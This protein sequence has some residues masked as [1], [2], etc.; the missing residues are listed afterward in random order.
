MIVFG[1]TLSEIILAGTDTAGGKF[2]TTVYLT[3]GGIYAFLQ[4]DLLRNF[5]NNKVLINLTVAIL[6]CIF[7]IGSLGEFPYYKVI[8]IHDRQLFL[9]VLH[10]LLFPIEIIVISFAIRDV[11]SGEFLTPDKLWGSA[12]VFLMVG[13]SFASFY[14]LIC[15]VRPESLGLPISYALAN[16]SECVAYSLSILGGMDP[17]HPQS[18]RFIRNISIIEAVWGNLFVVLVI[19]KLMTLP[20]PPKTE[21]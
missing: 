2:V 14:H 21:A 19:G 12:C 5:T 7:I 1:L 17:G 3:F 18:S 20:R 15:I 6:V 16:Y 9:F 11:F 8:E 10:S 13:M 4:W